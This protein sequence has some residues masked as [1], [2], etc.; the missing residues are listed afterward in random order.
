MMR[1][2]KS[3]RSLTLYYV[4]NKRTNKNVQ[5]LFAPVRYMVAFEDSFII[6]LYRQTWSATVISEVY[7]YVQNVNIHFR[8]HRRMYTH[9]YY[10]LYM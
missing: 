4:E 10:P 7:T 9:L 2:N 5:L 6:S 3:E 1:G 8:F